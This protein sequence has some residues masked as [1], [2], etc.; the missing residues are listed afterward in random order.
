MPRE[1]SSLLSEDN[2]SLEGRICF[3]C[4]S[5]S[6]CALSPC[7]GQGYLAMSSSKEVSVLQSQAVGT[8]G[9]VVSFS[10]L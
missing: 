5:S 8:V 4:V 2:R 3:D 7:M 6:Q 1:P 9:F 10:S